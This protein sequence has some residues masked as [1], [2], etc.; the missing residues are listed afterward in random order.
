MEVKIED[1]DAAKMEALS[2]GR[3][4]LYST[5]AGCGH[6]YKTAFASAEVVRVE[7]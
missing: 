1:N 3:F 4:V 6:D 5:H 7:L 2:E